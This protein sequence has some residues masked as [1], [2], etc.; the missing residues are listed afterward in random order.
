[1]K[2]LNSC[3][4][5]KYKHIIKVLYNAHNKNTQNHRQSEQLKSVHQ[6]IYSAT[7]I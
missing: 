4:N 5:K 2:G 6:F 7:Y 1:M 3:K